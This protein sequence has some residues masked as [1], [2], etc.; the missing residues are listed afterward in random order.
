MDAEGLK[1]L[2]EPFGAVAVKP[3]VR[4]SWN[5]RRRALLRD[6]VGRRVYIKCDPEDRAAFAEAG[7]TPFTYMT[8][9]KPIKMA[10]W[11]LVESA[12][13]EPDD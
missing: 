4:R 9:G 1:A 6:S 12:Y 5:L 2:F 11:R 13:D 8:K 10:Y 7:S 3:H